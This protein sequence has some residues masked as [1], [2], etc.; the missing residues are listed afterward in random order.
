MKS[1]NVLLVTGD[2]TEAKKICETIESWGYNCPS[3]VKSIEK[4]LNIAYEFD[5]V[6]MDINFKTEFDNIIESELKFPLIY[7]K[8]DFENRKI[9][10][11]LFM[12][13]YTILYFP[14]SFN[15]YKSS[16]EIAIY[17][18]NI[19]KEFKN[20]GKFSKEVL[21]AFHDSLFVID[22]SGKI[23]DIN[24]ASTKRLERTKDDMIGSNYKNFIPAETAELRCKYIERT[25][26]LNKI[27]EFEDMRNG[28]CF[29]H[30]LLPLSDNGKVKRI[31][32]NSQDITK[33]KDD[34]KAFI[35]INSYNRILIDASIDPFI[36]VNPNGEITDANKAVVTV[37]GYNL[38]QVIGTDF[39]NYFTDRDYALEGF[40]K[41][42]KNGF[43]ENYPLKIMHKDGS[44]P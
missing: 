2:S 30:T 9:D 27:I 21:D 6:L 33:R 18:H 7:L 16:V 38:E 8:K 22:T 10:K 11:K 17:K 36:T 5:V 34:E 32:V 25:I 35:T 44:Y 43:V 39:S 14:F 4:V 19:L 23:L 3:V 15:E 28:T 40:K 42:F 26:K 29:H 13:D 41:V 20:D 24:E 31:V 37:T 1:L 12:E